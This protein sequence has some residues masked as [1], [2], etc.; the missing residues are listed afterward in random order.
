MNVPADTSRLKATLV[1]A[2]VGRIDKVPVLDF[3]K[4]IPEAMARLPVKEAVS[5]GLTSIPP[6]PVS[7]KVCKEAI[8]PVTAR[9]P[10]FKLS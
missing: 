3:V 5:A 2:D 9:V 4:V 6:D 10:L 7:A 1:C 8:S